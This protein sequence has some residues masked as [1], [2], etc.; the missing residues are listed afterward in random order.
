V[1]GKCADSSSEVEAVLAPQTAYDLAYILQEEFSH[2]LRCL[3]VLLRLTLREMAGYLQIEAE[4]RQM[5]TNQIVQFAGNPHAFRYLA[6]VNQQ[7]LRGAELRI[8]LGQ[9]ISSHCFASGRVRH[10]HCK[11]LKAEPRDGKCQR[12]FQ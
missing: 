2:R 1:F 9:F 7:L 8:Q 10:E 3:N 6:A 11:N 12:D 4:P 5:M